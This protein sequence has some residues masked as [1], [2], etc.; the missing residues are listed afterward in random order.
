MVLYDSKTEEPTKVT[1]AS[2]DTKADDD[3]NIPDDILNMF[4][5]PDEDD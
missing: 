5:G 4:G 1:E 2:K 3:E